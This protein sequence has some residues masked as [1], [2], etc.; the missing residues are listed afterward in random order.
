LPDDF[1][2]LEVV[3][4]LG[5]IVAAVRA[6]LIQSLAGSVKKLHT[7]VL[8][9]LGAGDVAG[10]L[11]LAKDSPARAYPRVAEQV[12]AAAADAQPGEDA[13]RIH[14]RLTQAYETTFALEAWRI[15]SSRGRDLV[16]LAV[17]V[18]A[19]LYASRA[20]LAIGTLFYVMVGLGCVLIVYSVVARRSLLDRTRAASAE[21][22]AASSKLVANDVRGVVGS[23]SQCGAL[24]HIALAD[25]ERLDGLSRLGVEELRICRNCGHIDGQVRDAAAVPVSAE[26][27]TRLVAT[28]GSEEEQRAEDEEPEG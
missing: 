3:A 4:A 27:G 20:D 15:Q 1:P 21:L 12:I 2:T 6:Y 24:E 28:S 5:L 14:Q 18:S 11:A 9:R 10:A 23:C 25:P 8:A 13:A 16:V 26:L 22:I 7:E 19:L 17:L